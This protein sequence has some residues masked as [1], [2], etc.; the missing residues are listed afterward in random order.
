MEERDGKIVLVARYGITGTGPVQLEA[1]LA[2]A[3][4]DG[5]EDDPPAGA[6]RPRVHS[7]TTTEGAVHDE[8]CTV[9]GPAEIDLVVVPVAD[10]A[11]D[12]SVTA[13]PLVL[14]QEQFAS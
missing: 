4:W 3:T 11:T 2:V 10:T 6:E 13:T 8:R 1:R 7:W 12:I 5:R 9:T 14:E